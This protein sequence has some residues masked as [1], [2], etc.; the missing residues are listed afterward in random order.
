MA[1]EQEEAYCL[2]EGRMA[3]REA[4]LEEQLQIAERNKNVVTVMM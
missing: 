4:Q 1:R 3:R 2:E